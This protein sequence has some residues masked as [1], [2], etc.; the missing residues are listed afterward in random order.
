MTELYEKSIRTLELPAVLEM[1]AE[2]AVSGP[3]KDEVSRLRPARSEYEVKRR[4]SQTTA[5]KGMMV[6]KGSPS[7]SGIKDVRSSLSRANM[8]GLL[9]TR[10]LLDIAGVLRAARTVRAYAAGEGSGEPAVDFLFSSLM[11][12]K[13]LEEKI[14]NSIVGED[15]IADSASA[16]LADIRRHIR[17]SGARI[18][19]VLQKIISSPAY[20]KVLQEPII[21]TRS[22]RYVVPVKAEHKGAIQGLVH[23]VSASGATLFIEPM[24]VV[25]ENNEIRELRAKE[26]Q[27]IERILA[28][29]SAECGDHGDDITRD[30]TVLVELDS[31]FA[32]AKL[33]YKLDCGEPVISSRK[34]VL[35][36]ARHPLLPKSAAVPI[37]LE[38]G[39]DFDTLV[40]TGPNTGGKTV[41]LKTI[42][43]L[44]I[45][46][47]CGLHIPAADGSSIPFLKSVLA[48]I[49]DEQSIEQSLS[50]FSSHM[51]TIVK[52]LEECQEQS[53]LLFDE[54]GA[55]T[56][57]VEG[58]ALATA[59]IE[60]ARSRGAMIAAT[61]HY[62]ELKVYATTRDG[63]QNASCEFDVES[64]RPTYKLLIGIPGKSNAFAISERL[65]LARDII[66]D[67]RGRINPEKAGFEATIER[68]EQQRQILERD[69]DE[70]EKLL[71]TAEENAKKSDFLRRELTVRLEKADE[72]ARRDAQRILEE[73]RQT[74]ETAFDEID[75]MRK[76]QAKEFDHARENAARAELRRSMNEAEERI[77]K[78]EKK[79][80]QKRKIS[81]R[82]ARVGDTVEHIE[83]GLKAQVLDISEDRVLSLQAGAIKLKAAE[84]E[85]YILEDASEK[86]KTEKTAS[87]GI[88]IR[89]AAKSEL[90]LRGMMTDE[91]I[92]ILERYIDNAMLSKLEQVT[93]IHGKGTGALRAAVQQSLKMNKLIKKYRL[94]RFGEGEDG[95]TIVELK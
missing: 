85:V 71:R 42:G 44:C 83:M 20:G 39:T 52:V 62:A 92:P 47:F 91:A 63:V 48:D 30:F 66:D 22:E 25:K 84:N 33:S 4:L 94:G 74:A 57:P 77:I 26:K 75:E 32:R 50:T 9:N 27:E 21:T 31:I 65:G 80:E 86:P 38:L 11:A 41:S 64:L 72:K 46:A 43:L 70:T 29:L 73:A 93:I 34:L 79:Q 5:A 54:L 59:I 89:E 37:D 45:M 1:L 14:T 40:I 15:E 18:R 88:G 2:E 53:L 17:A 68:L 12:N 56:D 36:R 82:P 67:A 8:G 76:R 23:D 13:F 60:K 90:D 6:L 10:E 55:G 28:E 24:T 16:V 81:S 69:R 7:F 87:A 61:T 95:V 51:T 35:K 49:G 58:A 3:A 78:T 19:D